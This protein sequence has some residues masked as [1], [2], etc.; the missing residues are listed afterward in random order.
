MVSQGT[1]KIQN[2]CI[3]GMNKMKVQVYTTDL[4]PNCKR[5]KKALESQKKAYKEVKMATSEA[6]TEL[7]MNGVFTMA[8]PVL[9]VEDTFYTYEKLFKGD[10]LDL[11]LLKRILKDVEE[12]VEE[13]EEIGEV[14]A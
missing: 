7:N 13:A 6:L 12:D 14:S 5:L 1:A 2:A 10:D 3:M 11:E 9:Q 4:C 8:A